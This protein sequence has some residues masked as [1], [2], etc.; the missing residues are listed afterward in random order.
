MN[1]LL[2]LASLPVFTE[3]GGGSFEPPAIDHEFSPPALLF[4]GTPF[5]LNRILL[6]RLISAFV[7]L[8][9]M[10]WYAK[11]AKLVPGRGQAIIESIMDISR[12]QIADEVIGKEAAKAYQPMLMTIFM[13]VFFMNITG[14]IPG[15]Q[16]AGTSLIGMPLIYAIFAYIG[17]IVAGIKARGLHFFIEQLAPKGVP[18]WLY[19]IM[20]PIEFLSNFILRPVTLT[21][22]LF[23]NMIAGHLILVLCFVGTHFLYF[24]LSGVL[25]GVFGTLT[26][27]AGV[28]FVCFEIMVGALQAYI[29]AMLSAAYISLSISEH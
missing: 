20:V 19:I 8:I 2:K 23:M 14:I 10:M 25:G 15:L 7:I 27:V 24:T 18:W 29:F 3:A 6:I 5:E 22:R 26:F 17:F 9:L 12:V 4:A 16:I 1:L 28:A 21:F 13:G 11:R